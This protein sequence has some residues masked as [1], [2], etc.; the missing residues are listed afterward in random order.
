MTL[1]LF[2]T[3]DFCGA[4]DLVQ[5][6]FIEPCQGI[7]VGSLSK[8]L[9]PARRHSL[10]IKQGGFEAQ[11]NMFFK[12]HRDASRSLDGFEN[13]EARTNSAAALYVFQ[14]SDWLSRTYSLSFRS[15]DHHE[16]LSC[17]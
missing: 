2:S 3:A 7:F 11:G 6:K 15:T 9:H 4:N 13:F 5:L 14:E 10:R 17:V 8:I 16:K 12:N 1:P